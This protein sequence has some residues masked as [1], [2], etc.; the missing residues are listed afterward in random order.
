MDY[1]D[2]YKELEVERT[3]NAD[4]IKKAYR[5]LARAYH[6]D[7]N[8]EPGAED[9]FKRVSE[10]YEVLS[11]PEK[12]KRYDQLS[13]QYNSFQSKGGSNGN[14]SFDEFSRQQDGFSF[15]F[16]INDLFGKQGGGTAD[17]FESLFGSSKGKQR[18]R[19]SSRS[20]QRQEPEQKIYSV[21]ITFDEALHGTRKRLTIGTEKLDV[22]FKPGIEDKQRLKIPQGILEVTVAPHPRYVRDGNDLKV[23]ESIPLTTALLGGTVPIVTPFGTIT[24]KIPSGTRNDKTF[25][26][27]A[28]GMPVY[29]SADSRGDLFVTVRI[30]LP[31]SLTDEQRSLVE[32]LK[33]LGL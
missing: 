2:Y 19:R 29:G 1:R 5:R 20:T 24:M 17:F 3:A 12:K 31:S 15:D 22:Q 21:T 33:D 4:D 27:R 32:Q 13:T 28:H 23:T 26:V 6:P 8:S 25:R 14:T 10:A 16:D 7:T 30:I 11:D 9:R 18:G